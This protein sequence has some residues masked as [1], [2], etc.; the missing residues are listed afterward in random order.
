MNYKKIYFLLYF[1]FDIMV[2]FLNANEM[3]N[4]ICQNTANSM[5]Y[6]L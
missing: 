5:N 1:G 3:K 2:F 6:E 4:K